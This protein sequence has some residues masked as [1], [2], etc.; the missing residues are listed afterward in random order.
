MFVD[1][2]RPGPERRLPG[3]PHHPADAGGTARYPSPTPA[4]TSAPRHRRHESPRRTAGPVATQPAKWSA[5]KPPQDGTESENVALL[6]ERVAPL[7]RR[8]RTVGA[9]LPWRPGGSAGSEGLRRRRA[10]TSTRGP[11]R[12]PG[13][14]RPRACA[15]VASSRTGRLARPGGRRRACTARAGERG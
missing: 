9:G 1:P 6:S 7:C 10:G 8:R 14:C 13:F 12:G 5:K 11:A 3:A 4:A 2:A 15:A